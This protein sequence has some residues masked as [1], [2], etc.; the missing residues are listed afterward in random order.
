MQHHLRAI[1]LAAPIANE[2]QFAARRLA[3]QVLVDAHLAVARN[4]S[5]GDYQRQNEVAPRWLSRGRALVEEYVKRDQ[6]DPALRLKV[7]RYIMATAA[8][9]YNMDDPARII[10]DMVA[11]GRRLIDEASDPLNASRLEWE[12]GHALA[13]AV[14]LQRSRGA[15]DEAIELADEA[16]VLMQHSAKKRQST[17]MQK[18]VV[19]R[20]YFHVG[21]LQAVHQK[22]HEEAIEWYEKAQ[23][24]LMKDVPTSVFANPQVFGEY[25]ISMGVSYWSQHKQE[26]AIELTEFGTDIIQQAVSDGILPKATLAIPYGNLA[27]MH[28]QAGHD[29]DARAFAELA[30]DINAD[31]T[32]LR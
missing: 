16:L 9:L 21:S 15:Y 22:N 19:G 4:I 27:S 23:S 7:H 32:S 29:S 25:F 2:R 5:R 18:L 10:N 31:E 12:L 24:L 6:G 17:A 30:A 20:L 1:D 14:R 11:E 13:E 3:K 8:D 28:H 26:R